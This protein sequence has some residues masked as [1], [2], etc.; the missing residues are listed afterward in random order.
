MRTKQL[1]EKLELLATYFTLAANDAGNEQYK[2]SR[3][4]SSGRLA[5]FFEGKQSAFLT[6]FNKLDALIKEVKR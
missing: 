5:S 4:D 1:I 6:A 3:L 2:E